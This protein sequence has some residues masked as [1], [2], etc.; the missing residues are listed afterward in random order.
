M[1]ARYSD[2]EKSTTERK[3]NFIN[4]GK[5]KINDIWVFS[6]RNW[7]SKYLDSSEEKR[8]VL[9]LPIDLNSSISLDKIIDN[10]LLLKQLNQKYSKKKNKK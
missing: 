4:L 9:T 5:E 6:Q 2:P 3:T 7:F 8:K 1:F 10:R